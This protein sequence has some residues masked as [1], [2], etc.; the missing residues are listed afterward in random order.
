MNNKCNTCAK[1]LTCNRKACNKVTFV[2]AKILEKPKKIETTKSTIVDF[3][4]STEE[5]GK[6]L[7]KFTDELIKA[8]KGEKI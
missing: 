1:F 7:Q 4:I 2:Q 6:K 3:R 5:L 8:A